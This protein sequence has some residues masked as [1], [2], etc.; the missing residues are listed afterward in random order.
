MK[1][2]MNVPLCSGMQPPRPPPAPRPNGNVI[3][4][5]APLLSRF[6]YVPDFQQVDDAGDL[7]CPELST[8]GSFFLLSWDLRLRYTEAGTHSN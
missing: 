7:M 4:T 1:A 3:A 6:R 5:K 8:S 2:P